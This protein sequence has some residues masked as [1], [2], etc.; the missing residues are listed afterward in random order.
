M[1]LVVGDVTG[2][3]LPAATY[4]AEIKFTLRAFLRDSPNPSRALARLNHYLVEGRRLD[5]P[6]RSRFSEPETYVSLVVVV[7]DTASCR[8]ACAAAGAEPPLLLRADDGSAEQVESACGPLLVMDADSEYCAAE[9]QLQEGDLLLL[10]TDGVTEARSPGRGGAF[11]GMD[12]MARA[13]RGAWGGPVQGVVDEVV[14]AALEFAH[15]HQQDDICLLA[16]RCS[17][18]APHPAKRDR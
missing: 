9:I 5:A 17:P 16:L 8:A 7:V 14:R 6:T 13:A 2:K 18:D 12:G 11:F 15:G 3:G 4:T 10:A 1:A